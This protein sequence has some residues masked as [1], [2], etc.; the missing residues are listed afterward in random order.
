MFKETNVYKV[1]ILAKRLLGPSEDYE[2]EHQPLI[3]SAE[4][5]SAAEGEAESAALDTWKKEDGWQGHEAYIAIATR[6]DFKTITGI[7][8]RG[9]IITRSTDPDVKVVKFG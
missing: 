2:I 9:P 6:E 7:E 3:I 1:S 8:M 5:M 4:S